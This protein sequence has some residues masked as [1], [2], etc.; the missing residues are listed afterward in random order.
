MVAR[1]QGAP[2]TTSAKMSALRVS[3]RMRR[4][5][6]FMLVET[7]GVAAPQT[8]TISSSSKVLRMDN[9]PSMARNSTANSSTDNP[10]NSL[11]SSNTVSSK[12]MRRRN[13]K[14]RAAF[15]GSCSGSPVAPG[16][17]S[18]GNLRAMVGIRSSRSTDNR[19]EDQVE[20]SGLEAGLRWAPVVGC[21]AA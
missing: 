11:D 12:A 3:F 13:R 21:S 17:R 8:G 5:H 9:N 4:T 19:I 14:R 10:N 6:V 15:S 18:T 20:G 2:R 7:Q 16:R 1:R